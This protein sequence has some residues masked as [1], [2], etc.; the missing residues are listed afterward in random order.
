MKDYA[1]AAVFGI[2]AIMA[3]IDGNIDRALLWLILSHLQMME[4]DNG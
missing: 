2:M 1:L 4:A 3:L